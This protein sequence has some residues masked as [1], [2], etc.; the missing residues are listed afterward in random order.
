[1]VLQVFEVIITIQAHYKTHTAAFKVLIIKYMHIMT[2]KNQKCTATEYFSTYNV[3]R[4]VT[5]CSLVL[6]PSFFLK[7]YRAT[8]MLFID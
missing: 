7:R 1:M 8:V 2:Y 6:S 3:E 5:R 4:K